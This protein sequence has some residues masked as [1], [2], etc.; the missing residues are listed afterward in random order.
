MSIAIIVD[1][2]MDVWEA[3]VRD[4]LVMA[5]PFNHYPT[6]A[7]AAVGEGS[8]PSR[9]GHDEMARILNYLRGLRR[10]LFH[11]WDNCVGVSVRAVLERGV[12]NA[13]FALDMHAIMS[14]SPYVNVN[15]MEPSAPLPMPADAAGHMYVPPRRLPLNLSCPDTDYFLFDTGRLNE[16]GQGVCH[17]L[18]LG[19]TRCECLCRSNQDSLALAPVDPR[20]RREQSQQAQQQGMPAPNLIPAGMP[21]QGPADM[22]AGLPGPPRTSQPLPPVPPQPFSSV[23]LQATLPG[24]PQANSVPF[25]SPG[26]LAATANHPGQAPF[27]LPPRPPLV[28]GGSALPQDPRRS[29]AAA[30][31]P[32]PP[33]SSAP[34]VH[35]PPGMSDLP[36]APARAGAPTAPSA[37]GLGAPPGASGV[38]GLQVALPASQAQTGTAAAPSWQHDATEHDERLSKIYDAPEPPSLAGDLVRMKSDD[39]WTKSGS[40]EMIYGAP[41]DEGPAKGQVGAVPGGT[42]HIDHASDDGEITDD[43]QAPAIAADRR[44][45]PSA[46][47][48]A[49][50]VRQ[51]PV[52]AAGW[53]TGAYNEDQA[54]E[55]DEDWD[56]SDEPQFSEAEVQEKLW[57]LGQGG[58]PFVVVAAEEQPDGTVRHRPVRVQQN[59]IINVCSL[60]CSQVFQW[61]AKVWRAFAR[62][63]AA[64]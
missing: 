11:F 13:F 56:G 33:L 24:P 58:L 55:E 26:A 61:S 30:P 64:V 60:H 17:V 29:R 36:P 4:Q 57:T 31:L 10:D 16:S 25:V 38:P 21:H 15:S 23:Q 63:L 54:W 62:L 27:S 7:A 20:K 52:E 53:G 37:P 8:G 41:K 12:P 2:R 48:K 45:H 19:F 18:C 32:P 22:P 59:P 1:D 5:A 47:K 14:A 3:A 46:G 43:D 28:G 49:A 34:T 40:Y 44:G 51:D 6:C 42:Q 9:R 39:D 35:L 50:R